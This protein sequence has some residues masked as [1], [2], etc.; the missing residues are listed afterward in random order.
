[1]GPHEAYWQYYET[2]SNV[3]VMRNESYIYYRQNNNFCLMTL[4]YIVDR[5][6][7]KKSAT[8]CVYSN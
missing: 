3:P 5:E 2:A 7:E 6:T 4:I 1:M 8:N